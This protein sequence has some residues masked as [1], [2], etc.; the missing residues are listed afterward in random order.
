[1]LPALDSLD[2]HLAAADPE[3]RELLARIRKHAERYA[4]PH[5]IPAFAAYR[6]MDA[7]DRNELTALLADLTA[8]IDTLRPRHDQRTARQELRLAVLLD[9]ALRAQVAAAPT[10]NVRDAAMA[11]TI[12]RMLHDGP[13]RMIVLAANT[14]LQ[15]LPLRLGPIELPVAGAYLADELG[16]GYLAIAVTAEGGRTPTRRPSP[17]PTGV[18]LVDVDLAPPAPG[19]IESM[20][21]STGS[22]LRITDLRPV[23][24][25]GVLRAETALRVRRPLPPGAGLT[26]IRC[27]DSY[28]EVP[29]ADAF[30]L[31]AS[32]PRIGP[33]PPDER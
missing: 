21:T 25:G 26:H 19:S 8:R 5:A 10:V 12:L 13:D 31:V 7:A 4:G 28:T 14:H 2:R 3:G 9:Q 29:V 30:D 18:E 33:L 1:M 27:L 20:L 23:R 15:R 22:G 6:A 11:E 16:D 24:A 17:G 32:V